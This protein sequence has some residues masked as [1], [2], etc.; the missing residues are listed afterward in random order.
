MCSDRDCEAG[1]WED[2]MMEFPTE[3]CAGVS[4]LDQKRTLQALFDHFCFG[5]F[6]RVMEQ[7]STER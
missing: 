7:P 1:A 3:V 4:T 5:S 2:H 6:R